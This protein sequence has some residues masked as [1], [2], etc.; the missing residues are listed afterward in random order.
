[1]FYDQTRIGF[2]TDRPDAQAAGTRFDTTLPA[3]S[4]AGHVW[5]TTLD[6]ARKRARLEFLKTL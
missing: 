4:N 3:N 2:V 5:G 6:A 1:M